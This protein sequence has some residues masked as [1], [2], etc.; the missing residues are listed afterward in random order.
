[1]KRTHSLRFVSFN[2]ILFMLSFILIVELSVRFEE[3]YR[4]VPITV[5]EN[6]L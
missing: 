4:T 2:I 6:L 3:A 5:C 1:M